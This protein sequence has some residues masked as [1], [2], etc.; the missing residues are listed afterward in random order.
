M[1]YSTPVVVVASAARTTTGNSGPR[2]VPEA[3]SQLSL[4]VNVTATAGTPTLDLT[5]EWSDDGGTTFASADTSDA[6]MQITAAKVT[7]K[8]FAVRAPIYRVVWTVGGTTPSFTFS[9]SAFVTS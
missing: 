2:T 3:G 8:Q 1:A 4:W 9:V 5:V 7:V 6:F